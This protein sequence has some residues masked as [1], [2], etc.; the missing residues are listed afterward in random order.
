MARK[1]KVWG[2]L[3]AL[4]GSGALLAN[5]QTPADSPR[6]NA[7]PKETSNDSSPPRRPG[8][9]PGGGGGGERHRPNYGSEDQEKFQNVRRALDALTP[10][11]R[12]RFQENFQRWSNFSPEDKKALSDRESFRH[13]K[14]AEDIEQAIKNTNLELA[15]EQRA[16][17]VKRYTEERHQIEEQIRKDSDEKRQPLLAE[18][19]A[20]LKS[21]FTQGAQAQKR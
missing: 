20:K 12:K 18:M 11:Q 14:M 15:P 9:S 19:L 10:E 1:L 3:V 5:A 2:G 4:I 7:T 6:P 16:L 21:E 13:R 17:F 8:F